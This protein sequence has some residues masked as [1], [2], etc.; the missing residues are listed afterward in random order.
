MRLLVPGL[1]LLMALGWSAAPALAQKGK[2][3]QQ[4]LAL[5]EIEKLGGAT[6]SDGDVP[7]KP[8]VEVNL[9][10]REATDSTLAHL[11]AFP[12][13][14]R[15]F[16]AECSITDKGLENLEGL[17]Q[18]EALELSH[19]NPAGSR[20]VTDAGLA[21]LRGCVR[22][23]D[24]YLIGRPITD[25]GLASLKGMTE[26]QVL[27]LYGTNI[28]DKGLSNLSGLTNLR[29]LA[30]GNNP[31]ITDEGLARLKSLANLRELD[32]AGTEVTDAGVK[33]LQRALPK[34]K[35]KQ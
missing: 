30:L 18:L 4:E 25:T 10:F 20:K 24:L 5:A 6:E 1:V 31:R 3:K 27:D 33:D 17:K 35:I 22:M 12:H 9:R 11:K 8:V 15:L 16:L 26:L 13:L 7:G 21:H 23:K 32:V 2:D 19:G 34:V 29:K 28:T 14:K